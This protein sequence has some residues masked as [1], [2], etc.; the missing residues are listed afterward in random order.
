MPKRLHPPYRL[1]TAILAEADRPKCAHPHSRCAHPPIG[2]AHPALPFESRSANFKA[3]L[4][5]GFAGETQRR[6][7]CASAFLK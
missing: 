7:L 3:R 1:K 5:D 2:A 4:A 6:R